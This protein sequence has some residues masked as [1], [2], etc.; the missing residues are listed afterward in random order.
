MTVPEADIVINIKES[1]KVAWLQFV[2]CQQSWK[3]II[4]IIQFS[5]KFVGITMN[6]GR[7]EFYKE[8]G[9]GREAYKYLFR[10]R[11]SAA[12]QDSVPR[13]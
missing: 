8:A 7:G 12:V 5:H 9:K 1:E 3:Q 11:I 10:I 6:L 2:R 13:H 4:F